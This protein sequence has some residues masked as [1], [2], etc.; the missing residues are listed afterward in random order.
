[1]DAKVKMNVVNKDGQEFP[2][3]AVLEGNTTYTVNVTADW[4][5]GKQNWQNILLETTLP[6]GI[7]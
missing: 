5:D 1:M 3:G 2:N 6:E 4:L 7:K